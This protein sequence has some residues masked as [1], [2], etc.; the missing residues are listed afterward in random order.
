MDKHERILQAYAKTETREGKTK[1]YDSWSEEYDQDMLSDGYNG[2]AMAA[3]EVAK[4]YPSTR[5]NVHVLDVAAGTGLVGQ[6]LA[7]HGFVKVDALDPS[8]GMLDTAKEKG[9]YD[10]FICSYFGEEELAIAPDTYDVL[11][12]CGGCT[13]MHLPCNCLWEVVR[14]VKP[15]GYFVLVTRPFHLTVS[16]YNGRFEPLIDQIENEGKWKKIRKEIVPEYHRE[17]EGIVF[18]YKVI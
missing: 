15:G 1:F 11:V 5:E 7:K 4:L 16:E 17:Y 3:N 2:P 12:V 14:L 6:E 9:V 13:N 8:Q 10:K 18:V